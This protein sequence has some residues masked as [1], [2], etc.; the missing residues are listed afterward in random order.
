[1]EKFMLMMQMN[2]I[3]SEIAMKNLLVKD[4]FTEQ[5]MNNQQ[6][7]QLALYKLLG[8]DVEALQK[9]MEDHIIF[10]EEE[11]RYVWDNKKY[12]R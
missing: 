1:M 4:G 9:S 6:V 2:I 10:N 8:G 12:P 5:M 11:D 7:I 3:N